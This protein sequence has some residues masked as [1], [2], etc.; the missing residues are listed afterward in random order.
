MKTVQIHPEFFRFESDFVSTLKCI[1][2][3]VRY[4]LDSCGVKLKLHEWV[5][6][7]LADKE[8]LAF[9]PCY[10]EQEIEQYGVFVS[11]LVQ[12]YFGIS[13]SLLTHVDDSWNE[14]HQVPAEVQQKAFEYHC[15]EILL[16]HW[17]AMPTLQRFALVKLC[18]SGHEGKNFPVA[19]KE[20]LG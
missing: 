7:T 3:I 20:F 2:M 15:G 4:K 6:F 18:R 1:P 11:G 10:S 13:A 19:V 14:L 5:K 12:Q 8:T 9:L 17:I 16:K